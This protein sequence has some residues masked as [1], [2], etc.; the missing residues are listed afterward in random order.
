MRDVCNEVFEMIYNLWNVLLFILFACR[1]HV[2]KSKTSIS[3]LK[4]Q[5]F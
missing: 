2:Q 5:Q 1:L 3:V 4:M